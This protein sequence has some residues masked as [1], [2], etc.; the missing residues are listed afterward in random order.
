MPQVSLYL[1]NKTYDK[2]RR[3]AEAE[4]M[5]V[6]K[7]VAEKLTRAMVEDWPD[8]FDQLFGSI[9]DETFGAPERESF[10]SDAARENL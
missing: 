2:V 7:W 1:N 10:V 6:S 4:A 8:G 5:S 9:S 3:A